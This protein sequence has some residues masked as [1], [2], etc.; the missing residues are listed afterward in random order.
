MILITFAF[1]SFSFFIN[2]FY[3]KGKVV[4]SLPKLNPTTFPI[5]FQR[6][7]LDSWK[8]WPFSWRVLQ[9][10]FAFLLSL[11]SR[12]ADTL[13]NDP[14][15]MQR[16][17]KKVMIKLQIRVL[18]NFPKLGERIQ[19]KGK[20]GEKSKGRKRKKNI[21]QNL[22]H[23]RRRQLYYYTTKSYVRQSQYDTF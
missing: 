7:V 11:L 20:K 17:M 5:T 22:S 10:P 15:Y 4:Y 13:L 21:P 23:D 9:T 8:S 2:I 6:A 14:Y 12:L 18:Q 1:L 16:K 3:Q 19:Q